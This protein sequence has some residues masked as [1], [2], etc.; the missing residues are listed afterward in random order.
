MQPITSK[1]IS[2]LLNY[3]SPIIDTIINEV[4]TDSRK[5][6]SNTLFIAIKG[7][8]FDGHDFIEDVINKGTPLVITEKQIKNVDPKHQIIVP[9]TLKAFGKLAQHNRSFYK[10]KLIALTGSSGKTTT[11]ELLKTALSVYDKTYATTGNY[12]NHIGVPRTLLDI[13][14]TAPYA[15]VEMGMSALKE[16]EYLTQLASPDIALV[17]N[18]YPMH[19][20]FLKTLENIA[21]AKS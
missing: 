5:V 12:N 10:G 3:S 8:N 14:M 20:E 16:I 11:K 18:V 2:K 13:D 19:I 17:T 7:E 21:I 9:D 6:D 4:S 15:I 1:E